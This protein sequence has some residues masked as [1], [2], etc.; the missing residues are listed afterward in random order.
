MSIQA[1]I[2]LSSINEEVSVIHHPQSPGADES[3]DQMDLNASMVL[4]A[5]P[6]Q[7]E[8]PSHVDLSASM[9]QIDMVPKKEAAGS[10][11]TSPRPATEAERL[12]WITH[13]NAS[14]F[15]APSPRLIVKL[16]NLQENKEEPPPLVSSDKSQEP[17]Q[18]KPSN[19]TPAVAATEKRPPITIN[20]SDE[21]HS[22]PVAPS[23]SPETMKTK[24]AP[25]LE[26]KE[27]EVKPVKQGCCT[28]Q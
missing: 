6:T 4:V 5:S 12:S 10:A 7:Q 22:T 26:E 21:T 9:V 17:E 8:E 27:D 15:S 2:P 25:L 28:I 23:Q 13:L 19:Q 11:A 18:A 20:T 3:P 1:I 16:E 14:S 24:E